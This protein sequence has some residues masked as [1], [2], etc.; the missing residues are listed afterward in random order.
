MCGAADTSPGRRPQIHAGSLVTKITLIGETANDRY[1][2]LRTA[3]HLVSAAG[4]R[5]MVITYDTIP[6]S[7]FVAYRTSTGTVVARKVERA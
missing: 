3:E 1:F 2:A 5:D 6:P 7:D 4:K